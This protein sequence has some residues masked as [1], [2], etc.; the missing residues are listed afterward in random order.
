MDK[1]FALLQ[2]SSSS[3]AEAVAFDVPGA[4]GHAYRIRIVRA[5]SDNYMYLIVNTSEKTAVA[6]DPVDA[7]R[8]ITACEEMGAQLVAV[9]TTHYHADHS[10]G[11]EELRQ[12]FPGL[13]VLV[14]AGDHPRT[15]GVTGSVSNC[16]VV[17]FA[18]LQFQCMDT[19]CHTRGHVA[20]FLDARDG[21]S[22]ALFSGDALFVAGCG[23]FLEGTAMEMRNSLATL[24]SLPR[25]TRVFCGHEYTV[26]NLKF[27][28]SLE[29]ENVLV[30]SRLR[31][32]EVKRTA[33]VPTVPST[34]A[35]E[36]EHNPFLRIHDPSIAA[37]VAC[38]PND[39][40]NVMA[41]LRRSKDTFTTVGKLMT[42]GLDL[43]GMLGL[44]STM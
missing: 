41:R 22:P 5:L 25:D 44:R 35:E 24:A 23:R 43:T 2:C 33:G 17:Q 19:P 27:A 3:T 32:A 16:E 14:G 6:V 8:I 13:H 36:L 38:D 39:A 42:W 4:P 21:Q 37:A 11:N 30:S 18:G 12:R 26:T 20:F 31:H 15:P 10:G 29:P 1:L 40:L 34:I 7:G 9:L 28:A